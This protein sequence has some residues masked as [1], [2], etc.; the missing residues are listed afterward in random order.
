MKSTSLS[1]GLF[2]I[3]ALTDVSTLPSNAAETK[4]G[5]TTPGPKEGENAGNKHEGPENKKDDPQKE[6]DDKK[7]NSKESNT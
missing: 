3:L 5:I 6:P 1:S 2:F 7:K 4:P